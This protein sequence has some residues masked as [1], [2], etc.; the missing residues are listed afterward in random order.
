MKNHWDSICF[1]VV[2]GL[3]LCG[4]NKLG[5][6]GERWATGPPI[7]KMFFF[8]FRPKILPGFGFFFFFFFFFGEPPPPPPPQKNRIITRHVY[9]SKIIINKAKNHFNQP[10][11][12]WKSTTRIYRLHFGYFHTVKKHFWYIDR[13]KKVSLLFNE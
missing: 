4:H 2:A 1:D 5:S 6:M 11:L 3:Y 10:L 12:A 7:K 13:V 8:F 9:L